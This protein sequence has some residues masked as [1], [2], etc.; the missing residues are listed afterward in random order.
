MRI[1]LC[2]QRPQLRLGGETS[3]LPLADLALVPLLRDADAVDAAGANRGDCFQHRHI[4]RQ[5][6]AAAG[7][8][9]DRE[10][11]PRR[12]GG[13]NRQD[14]H[15]VSP[16]RHQRG[17][18]L[19]RPRLIEWLPRHARRVERSADDVR[20]RLEHEW[21]RIE[22]VE[23]ERSRDGLTAMELLLVAMV[24]IAVAGF[25]VWFFFFSTSPIDQRSGR[26]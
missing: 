12:L 16:G 26:H 20:D 24:V 18:R 7:Q 22:R 21:D 15:P 11:V 9:C 13:R 14:G 17:G 1:D 19:V 2:A 3:H 23:Y 25:E 4:I 8:R 5:Q 6:P 10:R